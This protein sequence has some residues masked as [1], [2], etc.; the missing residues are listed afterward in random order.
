[1]FP[2]PRNR[3]GRPGSHYDFRHY[4]HRQGERFSLCGP[5]GSRHII[6]TDGYPEFG[7]VICPCPSGSG[8]VMLDYRPSGNDGEPEV[9]YVDKERNHKA[10]K[11]APN[12]EAFIRGLVHENAYKTGLAQE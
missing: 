7:V 2:R 5:E 6:E 3:S 12:F 1:M 9:V 8:V 4:G 11:L 10:I